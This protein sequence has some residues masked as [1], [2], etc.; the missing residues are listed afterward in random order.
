MKYF[1]G[2]TWRTKYFYG[3]VHSKTSVRG[4]LGEQFNIEYIDDETHVFEAD[5]D[6]LAS[7]FTHFEVG[8]EV[9]V[10]AVAACAAVVT[11]IVLGG[12]VTH[13]GESTRRLYNR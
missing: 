4:S 10:A 1:Y 11:N 7:H 12:G 6:V 8:V 3:K 13:V 2:F 5:G 9:D